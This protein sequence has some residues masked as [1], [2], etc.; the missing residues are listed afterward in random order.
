MSAKIK[1]TVTD[2]S[3][4]VRANSKKNNVIRTSIPAAVR[5]SLGLAAGDTLLW[6]ISHD[7]V[8]VFVKVTKK[9]E[10]KE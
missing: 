8:R 2:E 3:A 7:G 10:K 4:V 6:D 1:S 9:E 5:N